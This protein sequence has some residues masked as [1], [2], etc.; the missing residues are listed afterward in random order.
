[1]RICAPDYFVQWRVL[2]QNSRGF[3]LAFGDMY[4][5]CR[6]KIMC[7]GMDRAGRCMNAKEQHY[8]QQKSGNGHNMKELGS[9]PVS[10][11]V[12]LPHAIC[13]VCECLSV[14][15]VIVT[16]DRSDRYEAVKRY[17]C[18]DRLCSVVLCRWYLLSCLFENFW[19][20]WPEY[21]V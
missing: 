12:K 20:F 3:R 5:K 11:L 4:N 2:S 15:F 10:C 18:L 14:C 17:L 7:R 21:S 19:H 9:L 8:I 13:L 6:Q 16:P 1:M